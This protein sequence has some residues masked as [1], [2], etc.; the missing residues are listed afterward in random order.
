VAVCIPE[1]DRLL[2]I[3][4]DQSLHAELADGLEQAVTHVIAD[5][6]GYHQALVDQ[7]AHDVCN[8]ER[9]DVVPAQT[10]RTRTRQSTWS[11]GI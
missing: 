8:I 11:E 1:F 2:L 6:V 3:R 9:I 5:L 7:G 10:E 4:F